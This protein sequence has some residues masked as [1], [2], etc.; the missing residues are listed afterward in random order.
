MS[1]RRGSLPFRI[2]LIA[3]AALAW[4]L[5]SAAA[6][7]LARVGT[8]S[9]DVATFAAR[10]ARLAPFQRTRFGTAWPE[11]RRHF[12]E[13]ELVREA[14]IEVQAAKDDRQLASARDSAL[15]RA[16]LAELEQGVETAGVPADQIAGYYAQ[17]RQNYEAPRSILIW[18]ILLR[19]E[20]E[21]RALLHELGTPTEGTWSRLARER[22]IDT[23]THMRAGSLGYVAAD[24]Q[25]H[26]PQVRVAAALFV[27]ADRVRD[28]QL[29]PEPVVEGEAFAVVWRRAS[30]VA[31]SNQLAT[32]SADIGALLR[33][34]KF[35]SETRTLI[36][37]LRQESVRDY[38]PAR[39]AGFE[40]RPLDVLE[41]PRPAPQAALAARPVLLNLRPGDS[42]LR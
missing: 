33:H 4:G 22:S 25:T 9:I 16:L 34:E 39:L 24:G 15:A 20:T 23:A 26:M 41:P 38:Q 40:P 14:L 17:H 29:V 6:P 30:R 32:V 10:A 2:R 11:Q 42:G 31:A 7:S 12:L 27:A 3:V 36:E 8:L 19:Q 13:Q 1:L 28:G 5:A 37:R 35:A 21:A 18:R